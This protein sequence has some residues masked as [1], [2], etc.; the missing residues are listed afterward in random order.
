MKYLTLALL[1]LLLF[2]CER[3]GVA[4]LME[5]YL[6]DK[7][8]ILLFSPASDH[9]EYV[10]QNRLLAEEA[11]GLEARDIVLWRIIRNEK[12]SID[13]EQKAHL[14]TPRF[15]DYFDTEPNRF[16]FILLG[17]DGG[18]KIRQHQPLSGKELFDL[19]DAMPMRQQEMLQE[20]SP[21]T[22][23]E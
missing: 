15:Y 9:P 11:A 4:E 1:S 2:A 16:T 6:W 13:G 22:R 19:I 21:K 10:K 8:V 17:K 23:V 14:G 12:V 20:N 3:S 5:R 7:R 18:E